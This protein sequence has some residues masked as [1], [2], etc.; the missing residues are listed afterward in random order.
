MQG[1]TA[2]PRPRQG[3]AGQTRE[4]RVTGQRPTH[5]DQ[6]PDSLP[7]RRPRRGTMLV[8]E[9]GPHL[10]QAATMAAGGPVLQPI[11]CPA[12]FQPA[13]VVLVGNQRGGVFTEIVRENPFD[14]T[15]FQPDAGAAA[16]AFRFLHDLS[17]SPHPCS[18]RNPAPV[19]RPASGVSAS[20]VAAKK[21]KKCETTL[22][23]CPAKRSEVRGQKRTHRTS[24]FANGLTS[25][26]FAGHTQSVASYFLLAIVHG[27]PHVHCVCAPS[28][29]PCLLYTELARLGAPCRLVRQGHKPNSQKN[30]TEIRPP[31]VH[32]A[33][34]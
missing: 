16:F 4:S 28:G 30:I 3:R 6:P 5:A 7:R 24:V 8:L 29:L 2:F 12:P 13:L 10:N 31:P 26:F 1:K 23:V 17:S 18:V 9:S 25:D 11:A 14:L 34:E 32:P 15:R 22:C 19:V 21:N 27:S 20:R 33:G